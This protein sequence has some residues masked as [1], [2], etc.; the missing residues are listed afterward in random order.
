MT[1]SL[2]LEALSP[3]ALAHALAALPLETRATVTATEGGT[4]WAVMHIAP[5][6]DSARSAFPLDRNGVGG[7]T[8]KRG[9]SGAIVRH[10][11]SSAAL[12]VVIERARRMY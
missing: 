6:T 8:R 7:D 11:D 2:T 1:E 5:L 9:Q 3:A 4:P 12:S 10:A